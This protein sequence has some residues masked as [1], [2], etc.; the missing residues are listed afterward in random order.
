MFAIP[1]SCRDLMR[2]Q[3]TQYADDPLAPAAMAI[4]EAACYVDHLPRRTPTRVLDIGCGLGRASVMLHI[5]YGRPLGTTYTM[6]DGDEVSPNLVGGWMPGHD[7][8]CNTFNAT[9]SFM[10]AN[11]VNAWQ[12]RLHNERDVWHEGH[13]DDAVFFDVI[14]SM[15]AV[16]FHWPIEPW[17]PLLKQLSDSDTTLIF[18]VRHGQYSADTFA[19][20]FE[21]RHLV[22]SGW[23]E[24]V[25]V[26]KGKRQ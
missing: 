1:E 14:V 23:K 9:R 11:G 6:I 4:R 7:E 2:L 12:I 5:L 24:D 8:W 20:E 26:L 16:G 19:G 22:E 13:W 25:L 3:V 21:E 10:W 18:G 17:L 15:L